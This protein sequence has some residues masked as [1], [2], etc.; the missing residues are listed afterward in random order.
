MP[1][2]EEH[3]ILKI[4]N[5]TLFDGDRQKKALDESYVA[6]A[7]QFDLPAESVSPEAKNLHKE[8][9]VEYVEA[10]NRI[11]AELDTVDRRVKSSNHAAYRGLKQDEIFNLNA[12]YL[13]EL[14]FANC[15]CPTSEIYSDSL[16]HM[17]LQRDWGDFDSWQRDFV[18]CAL[19]AREGWAVAGYH[20]FLKRYINF[21]VDSHDR[22]I[23]VG[24]YP[25]IVV[26][27]WN[28]SSR[29]FG[30]DKRTYLVSQL[31]ELNWPVIEQRF[32]RAEKI[33]EALK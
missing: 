28:H 21:F 19:S 16:A 17:R 6:Q 13:H 26:D 23:P 29:D 12:V 33:A 27:M 10:L 2:E 5:D 8:L 9:Y 7:K 4:I 18:A 25:I 31:R 22:S 20:T 32:E 3:Q 24:V 14:Y 11:S 1:Q 15:F 30:N